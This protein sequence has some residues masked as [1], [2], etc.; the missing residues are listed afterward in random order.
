LQSSKLLSYM[1]SSFLL[2]IL[3]YTVTMTSDNL[4]QP[5]QYLLK[6]SLQCLSV[7]GVFLLIHSMVRRFIKKQS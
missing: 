4:L 1:M 3:L 6:I 2:L 7:F 5:V